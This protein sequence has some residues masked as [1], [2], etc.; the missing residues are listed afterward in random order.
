MNQVGGDHKKLYCR[1][2]FL[3]FEPHSIHSEG[4][5]NLFN[6]LRGASLNRSNHE[7]T[8]EEPVE[9]E[10]WEKWKNYPNFTPIDKTALTNGKPLKMMAWLIHTF[11]PNVSYQQ[12]P[13]NENYTTSV[14]KHGVDF[15][16]KCLG[17][18]DLVFIFVQVQHNIDKWILLHQLLAKKLDATA[19][20]LGKKNEDDESS[21]SAHEKK[22]IATRG[23]EYPHGA[24][25]SGKEAQKR[26]VSLTKFFH[27][28]YFNTKGDP[29]AVKA[30]NA[31]RQALVD[32]LIK[33]IDEDESKLQEENGGENPKDSSSHSKKKRKTRELSTDPE[34]SEIMMSHFDLGGFGG[35]LMMEDCDNIV[36]M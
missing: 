9:V 8:N 28:S 22:D 13:T 10:E 21:L 32:E 31:N 20:P 16:G 24:G 33:M 4:N 17:L 26:Y 5:K 29:E 27:H 6:R 34:F 15:L 35:G 18:D 30:V 11:A 25:I 14:V 12:G 2:D 36:Q 19:I 3:Q 23:Y 1:W 7:Q